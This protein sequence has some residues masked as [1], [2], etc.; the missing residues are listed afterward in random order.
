MADWE[1]TDPDEDHGGAEHWIDEAGEWNT[2][3]AY[4]GLDEPEQ[5][6]S[7]IAFVE[8]LAAEASRRIAGL[9]AWK[10]EATAFVDVAREALAG[11]R[12][13]IVAL[14]AELAAAREALEEARYA[15][16]EDGVAAEAYSQ[17]MAYL[18]EEPKP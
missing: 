14:E 4:R 1:W 3:A 9:E 6:R 12:D 10:R 8:W 11:Q 18:D 5:G 13:R 17:A 2:N 16:F 7:D 15:A